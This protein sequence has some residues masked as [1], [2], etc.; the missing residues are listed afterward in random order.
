MVFGFPSLAG[1]ISQS[2]LAP[3][4]NEIFLLIPLHVQY[5]CR[6]AL[7]SLAPQNLHQW[8]ISALFCLILPEFAQFYPTDPDS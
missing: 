4:F 5:G 8:Q 2:I 7:E 3:P 6:E 1:Y